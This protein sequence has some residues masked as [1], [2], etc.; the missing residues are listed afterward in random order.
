M[1]TPIALLIAVLLLAANGFFVAAE[2][3]LLA[4]R[5]SR[6]EQLAAEGDRRAQHALAGLRELSLMLAGAQLGITM[7]SLGLGIIAE[8]AV[9]SV[10]E[11]LL[12]D[13]VDLPSGVSHAIA[14]ALALSIV[15]FLH[16]VVG[17]M[18][19]KSWAI[20]HPE[21]SALLLARP[22]RLFAVV[23]RPFI[24]AL[25]L[26]ANGVVRLAGVEPQDEL[27]MAHSSAD[28]V[29]MLDEAA[30]EGSI[31]VD[32]HVL[33]ARSLE[34]SGLD[35]AAAMT[36]RPRVV[37]VAE[38]ATIDEIE[39]IAVA[40]GRSRIVVVGTDLDHPVGVVHVRD[41]L[42]HRDGRDATA[43]D[44]AT[45]VLVAPDGLPL[46]LLFLRMREERRHL[47]LVVDE[48]GIVLGLVTMEDV[49]EELIGEFED[50]T[51]RR[52][53]RVRRQGDGSYLAA[54]SLRIDEVASRIDVSIP[55]GDWDTLAGFLINQLGRVPTEGD[56]VD[57][58]TAS[59]E[60]VAMDGVAVREVRIRRR[61][62]R[63]TTPDPSTPE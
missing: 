55:E 27:A 7:C 54:G 39:Q 40:T 4:A 11:D 12:H 17:E 41:V 14:F 45:P 63:G 25:N 24:R 60:V 18:A 13:L 3:A 47:A 9:A 42:T 38:T 35:A 59:F 19:P 2:F 58:A 31:E 29:L 10:F 6:I 8:P 16:M 61:A 26:A 62:R 36:P 49:L 57:T 34:L 44:L 37:S 23:F 53:R 30:E 20:A 33:L 1:S 50:E 21:P 28:L 52:A 22:F 48:H 32:E 51:D 5:R 43:G 46:E 56:A 15:V